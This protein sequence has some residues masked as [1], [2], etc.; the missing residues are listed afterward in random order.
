M[1]RTMRR[2]RQMLFVVLLPKG[3][4]V[5][6]KV[7]RRFQT[8]I[9]ELKRTNRN[10]APTREKI[11][12]RIEYALNMVNQYVE[13]LKDGLRMNPGQWVGKYVAKAEGLIELLEDPRLRICRGI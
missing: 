1:D 13:D 10:T 12:E 9:D 8:Q 4:V 2:V 5:E 11:L 7:A 6:P 3:M